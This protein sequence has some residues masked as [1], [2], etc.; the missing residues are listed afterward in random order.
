MSVT[1]VPSPPHPGPVRPDAARFAD[2]RSAVARS[3]GAARPTAGDSAA[4]LAGRPR[5]PR[6]AVEPVLQSASRARDLLTG[7]YE[8][9]G[10][11]L[12]RLAEL[13]AAALQALAEANRVRV[14]SVRAGSDLP[15]LIG[16]ERRFYGAVATQLRHGILARRDLLRD[17]ARRSA[18]LLRAGADERD[19]RGAGDRPA[20]DPALD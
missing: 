8:I 14:A 7:F 18:A 6:P 5:A 9:G 15:A 10:V 20:A 3:A 19:L 2:A 4:R 12:S 1:G 13:Q 17:A 11:S 16:A